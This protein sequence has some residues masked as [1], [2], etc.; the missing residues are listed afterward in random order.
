MFGM[1]R[2]FNPNPQMDKINTQIAEQ[3][4]NSLRKLATVVAYSN[5]FENHSDFRYTEK[6]TNKKS[7]LK[8]C[9]LHVLEL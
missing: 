4:N 3:L 1:Q 7:N 8:F 9:F 2:Y 5:I 6:S